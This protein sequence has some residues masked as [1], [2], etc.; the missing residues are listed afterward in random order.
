MSPEEQQQFIA[1]MKERGRDTSAFEAAKTPTPAAAPRRETEG[2]R[3]AGA[4]HRR[5]V[6]AA[7]DHGDARPRVAVHE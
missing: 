2:S 5:A 3:R 1:R 4:D 6:R 7:A